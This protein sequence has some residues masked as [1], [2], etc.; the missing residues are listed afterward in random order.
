MLIKLTKVVPTSPV[1]GGAV[2]INMDN[3]ARIDHHKSGIGSHIDFTDEA[4][5]EHVKETPDEIME[6][7][8]TPPN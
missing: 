5:E 1:G 6:M 8:W 3:V 2:V 7:C 4:L